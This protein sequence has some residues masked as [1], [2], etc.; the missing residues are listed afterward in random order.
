MFRFITYL[1]DSH[2]EL[3]DSNVKNKDAKM[4]YLWRENKQ[5][6][7]RMPVFLSG[8]LQNIDS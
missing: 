8:N 7:W 3:K 4:K 1:F 6:R 2:V 5:I